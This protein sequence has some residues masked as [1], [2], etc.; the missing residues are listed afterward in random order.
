MVAVALGFVTAGF[1]GCG[2]DE[3]SGSGAGGG[4]TTSSTQT[5]TVGTAVSSSSSGMGAGSFLGAACTDD[6]PCQ[7][8][9]GG[10][11]TAGRC[12]KDSDSE[13]ALATFWGEMS[14]GG[15]A[16]G[17]CT[18]DCVADADCQALDPNSIC[19]GD[20][21]GTGFCLAGC[22]FGSP[23]QSFIDEALPLDKCHG[24][25][26]LM[27]VPVSGG[28]AVCMPICGSDAECGSGRACDGRT[29][30]CTDTPHTGDE[31]GEA[32]TADDANTT[33]DEDNCAGFCLTYV[34]DNGDPVARNCSNRCSLGGDLAAT[35]NCGGPTEGL[36]LFGPSVNNVAAELGDMGFCAPGCQAHDDCNHTEG[37]FCFD[38]AASVDAGLGY[39]LTT[40]DCPSGDADCDVANGFKCTNT[41]YG[42]VCLEV[43]MT[44]ALFYDLGAADGGT[45]GSG[46][47][48]GAGGTGAGGAGGSGGN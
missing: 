37:I 17:Y 14:T 25:D 16:R 47:G 41:V 4:D 1:W 12:I 23:M 35:G 22:T 24:R 8:G 29:G 36:C 15:P 31:P 44:G 18:A 28:G 11:G 26:D 6:T 21:N 5:A 45:G 33:V 42:P 39:C 43:D 3:T 7:G 38:I 27:C 40:S 46:G 20:A 13:A 30:L 9:A 2:D 19:V 32:C 48:G 34:D 10:S